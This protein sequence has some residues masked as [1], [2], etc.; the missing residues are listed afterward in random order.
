MILQNDKVIGINA[1]E[2]STALENIK[3]TFQPKII[4]WNNENKLLTTVLQ[5]IFD[6]ANGKI[7]LVLADTLPQSTT[8]NTQYWVKTYQE[9]TLEN[10][11]FIIITDTLNVAHYIGTTET[12]L[13]EYLKKTDTEDRIYGTDGVGEQTTFAKKSTP[14]ATPNANTILDEVGIKKMVNALINNTDLEAM[15]TTLGAGKIIDLIENYTPDATKDLTEVEWN[16]S[17]VVFDSNYSNFTKRGGKYYGL[18]CKVNIADTYT[19]GRKKILE[20]PFNIMGQMV[21]YGY[22]TFRRIVD[23]TNDY[24]YIEMSFIEIN[25][26]DV[27]CDIPKDPANIVENIAINCLVDRADVED[28]GID[29]SDEFR[30]LNGALNFKNLFYREYNGMTIIS[31]YANMTN[32]S[33][34]KFCNVPTHNMTANCIVEDTSGNHHGIVLLDKTTKEMPVDTS[35]T[36][37]AMQIVFFNGEEDE[38]NFGSDIIE[39]N[40]DVDIRVCNARYVDGFALQE[41]VI[42]NESTNTHI[43]DES[44]KIDRVVVGLANQNIVEGSIEGTYTEVVE[45]VETEYA[46]I[47]NDG[48]IIIGEEEAGTIDYD[49]GTINWNTTK[50]GTLV[51]SYDYRKKSTQHI[52]ETINITHSHYIKGVETYTEGGETIYNPAWDKIKATDSSIVIDNKIGN[53]ELNGMVISVSDIPTIVIPNIPSRHGTFM[54]TCENGKL[55]WVE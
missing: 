5:E 18:V 34:I 38:T 55:K 36:G 43:T 29:Y 40:P 6:V 30:E 12:D 46:V 41:I 47:D 13:T 42:Y 10:G 39:A 37:I 35:Y 16:K 8:A 23:G 1:N 44:V 32:V 49:F 45:E 53:V 50:T 24:N 3:I 25:G 33:K 15:D 31:F 9:E 2:F 48:K 27:Y 20:L 11:R 4:R 17:N 26:K 52:D 7:Q 19:K 22:L 51:L 54:L 14:N 21:V 28:N